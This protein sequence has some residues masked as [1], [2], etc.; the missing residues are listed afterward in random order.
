VL[1]ALS[2]GELSGVLCELRGCVLGPV[3]MI[4]R[5]FKGR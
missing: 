3:C 5:E 4:E 2:S 1:K